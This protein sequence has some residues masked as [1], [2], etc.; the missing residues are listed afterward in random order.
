MAF[1]IEI[2]K[3]EDLARGAAFLGTGGG[4]DPY[5]GRLV[6]QE[7]IR[8]HGAPDVI[9]FDDLDDDAMVYSIAGFGA[10]TVQVEKLVCGEEVEFALAKL[11]SYLGRK[12][13]ALLSAEIGGSNSMIPVM[14]AARRGLK[15]LDGDGMGRAFPELQMNALCANKIRVTPLVVIDEH[16][17]FAIIEAKTDKKAE[18]MTRALAI[19]MGLRVFIACF[20]MTGRQVKDFAVPKTLSIAH[21]VGQAIRKGGHEGDAVEYLL[22]ALEH[23]L[24][25]K[26]AR[27][28]FDGKIVDL[29][30]EI[31]AG[32]SVGS[33]HLVDLS[34]GHAKAVVRFQNENL[35]V[36]VNDK[37]VAIVPDLICIVD[38]ETGEPV[39]VHALR[40][41]QRVKV[42]GMKAPDQLRT[43]QSLTLFGPQGF[44]IDEPFV[45]I[46]NLMP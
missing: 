28:L 23:S 26:H 30:R 21:A 9:D 2:D 20:P 35:I 15:L 22:D 43:P 4:G 12:A 24:H 45:P 6:A 18:D 46:E 37:T 42:I 7:A 19:Q 1:K 17:N 25:Y 33:C 44:G 38:R 11:E 16:M 31:S 14:L 13:D 5:I 32:F 41:G 34:G 29:N 39:P 8:N 40:Y 27:V 36:R 3:L 10:P